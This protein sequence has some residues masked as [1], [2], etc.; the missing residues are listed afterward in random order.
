MKFKGFLTLLFSLLRRAWKFITSS[1]VRMA[2]AAFLALV[3]V[4]TIAKPIFPSKKEKAKIERKAQ[5][6]KL[7]RKSRKAIA[8]LQKDYEDA[9]ARI[10]SRGEEI[11]RLQAENDSLK[12]ISNL[13]RNNQTQIKDEIKKLKIIDPTRPSA[14][15]DSLLEFFS[16]Y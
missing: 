7:P 4:F 9:L 10:E 1:K 16:G 5:K 6:R 15:V 3:I 12:V 13:N 8:K 14:D 11:E 2:I